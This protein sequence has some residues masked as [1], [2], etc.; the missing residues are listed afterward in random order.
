[1]G[2]LKGRF[3]DYSSPLAGLP[4]RLYTGYFFFIYGLEKATGGF[5]GAGLRATLQEWSAGNGYSFYVP[6]LEGVVIPYA[7]PFAVLVTAGELFVGT[8]LLLGVATRL[9]AL[10]GVFL[11]LNFA[12]ASGV[13]LL[14]VE[15]PVVFGLLCLTVHA[16]A[17]GRALG[18]DF[19][20]KGKVPRWVA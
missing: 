4:A 2:L 17:A 5:S 19:L 16:T 12:L 8:A 9:F 20:L 18:L 10:V 14:S 6:F 3:E 15:R 11:C 7:G 1:M 13:A